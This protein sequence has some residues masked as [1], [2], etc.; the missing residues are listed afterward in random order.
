M[1]LQNSGTC[2]LG[3]EQQTTSTQSTTSHYPKSNY[4]GKYKEACKTPL[5][6]T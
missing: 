5:N 1:G 4:L 6:I 3:T 2:D